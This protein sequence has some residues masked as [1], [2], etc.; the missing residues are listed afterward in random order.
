MKLAVAS[1]FAPQRAHNTPQVV[2]HF[3]QAGWAA[4]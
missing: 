2:L 3:K 4:T 1:D